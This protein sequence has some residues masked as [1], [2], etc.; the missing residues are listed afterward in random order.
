MSIPWFTCII[1]AKWIP[2]R[3]SRLTTFPRPLSCWPPKSP[4]PKLGRDES[5]DAYRICC[6]SVLPFGRFPRLKLPTLLNLWHPTPPPPPEIP[7]GVLRGDLYLAH[8]HFQMNP[9]TW[10]KV[11][12]NRTAFP[13]FWIDDPLKPP[14]CPLVSWGQFVWRISNPTWICTCVPNLVPIG[15]IRWFLTFTCQTVAKRH[16]FRWRDEFY[17]ICQKQVIRWR[18]IGATG[19]QKESTAQLWWQS[20]CQ[21]EP[22]A[23]DS[24][25][26]QERRLCLGRPTGRNTWHLD[27][28]A[29]EPLIQCVL[30]VGSQEVPCNSPNVLPHLA[31]E[32]DSDVVADNS[33]HVVTTVEPDNVGHDSVSS[34]W[35]LGVPWRCRIQVI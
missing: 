30:P 32:C 25:S 35:Y 14:K 15:P 11:G 18:L 12:A 17:Q 20:P 7:P 22:V 6:Q 29:V 13:D 3:S 16:C 9:L 1:C 27:E 24:A 10:T 4:L 2:N 34:H 31:L 23:E 5:T 28:F 26:S 33:W 19:W 21:D 8:V